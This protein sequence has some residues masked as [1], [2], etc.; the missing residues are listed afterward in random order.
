MNNEELRFAG[1]I[2]APEV[3]ETIVKLSAEK[4]EG[5]ASVGA[6][7]DLNNVFSIFSAKKPAP[8]LPAVTVKVEGE[9][10]RIGVRLTVLFGYPFLT[11]AEEVR[12]AIATSVSSQV[13]AQIAGVDVYIDALVFPKE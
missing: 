5:V 6:L 3:V 2:V 12:K 8:A 1:L 7:G 4:V 11:L 9:A 10:L 13:G